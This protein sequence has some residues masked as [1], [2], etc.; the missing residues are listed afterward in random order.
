MQ[1]VTGNRMSGKTTKL[2][3]M[4]IDD[5]LEGMQVLLVAN[6][7]YQYDTMS[8]YI[9]KSDIYEAIKGNIIVHWFSFDDIYPNRL[10]G[11]RFDRIY[12]DD[13]DVIIKDY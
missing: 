1:V 10:T 3:E 13:L 9:F 5:A 12:I 11:R 6:N 4:A 2:I 7:R 8:E